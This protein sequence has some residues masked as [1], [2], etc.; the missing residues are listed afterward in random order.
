MSVV[1]GWLLQL[2]LCRVMPSQSRPPFLGGGAEQ[3]LFLCLTPPPHW[4]SHSDHSVHSDQWPSTTREDRGESETKK[5]ITSDIV[6]VKDTSWHHVHRT[7]LDMHEG[8]SLDCQTELH[9][10]PLLAELPSVCL[11]AETRSPDRRTHCKHSTL[12]TGTWCSPLEERK[13]NEMRWD[14][15]FSLIITFEVGILYILPQSFSS[16]PS[17]QSFCRSH[18]RSRWTHSPLAQENCFVEQ[19]LGTSGPCVVTAGLTVVPDKTHEQNNRT[20]FNFHKYLSKN[21]R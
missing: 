10:R 13:G 9:H 11:S 15:L 7:D 19:G 2:W 16:D 3:V 20:L 6:D 14:A 18:L 21:K 17:T 1:Q 5:S 12:S 4:A 8:N